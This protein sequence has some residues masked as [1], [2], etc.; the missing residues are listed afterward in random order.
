MEELKKLITNASTIKKE[1][2]ENDTYKK[3]M[4]KNI[5]SINNRIKGAKDRGSINTC[6][7]VDSNYEE[8]LKKMYRDKGYYFKPTGYIGGDWQL[9]EEI[10]W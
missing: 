3:E 5:N 2:V 10:C 8:D 7:I 9:S 4:T 6:F 1:T